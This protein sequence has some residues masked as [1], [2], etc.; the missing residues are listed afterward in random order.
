V[1][2]N[3]LVEQE[4][5][6][7]VR[8]GSISNEHLITGHDSFNAISNLLDNT[9]TLKSERSRHLE[10]RYTAFANL[11]VCRIE[12]C[13]L[14]ADQELTGARRWDRLGVDYHRGPI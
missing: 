4:I 12:T 13:G 8:R 14:N 7:I 3:N 2:W 11:P 1:H 10:P 5:R 9:S 6:Q